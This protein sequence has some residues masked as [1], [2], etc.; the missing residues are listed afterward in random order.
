MREQLLPL[1]GGYLGHRIAD[2]AG[3]VDDVLLTGKVLV[4][5]TNPE[6]S[7]HDELSER[8][9]R[10][11]MGVTTQCLFRAARVVRA[12]SSINAGNVTRS[13]DQAEP[14]AVPVAGDD[15]D[16][17]AVAEQLVR[18]AGC[19]PVVTGD[20]ASG[21]VFEWGNPGCFVNTNET[22]LRAALGM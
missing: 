8:S 15:P 7:C 16:A 6:P 20:L 11:G 12:F 2:D 1:R 22:G 9:R 10:D 14:F 19:V 3:G 18:D 5:A 4:D 13:C 21:R 17:V